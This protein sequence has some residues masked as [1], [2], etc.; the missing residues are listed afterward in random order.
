MKITTL[1]EEA[2]TSMPQICAEYAEYLAIHALDRIE[3]DSLV[4]EFT[5]ERYPIYYSDL[6]RWFIDCPNSWEFCEQAV[7]NGAVDFSSFSMPDLLTAGWIEWAKSKIERF[8][9]QIA[10]LAALTLLEKSHDYLPENFGELMSDAEDADTVGDFRE[11]F[12]T[13]E[14]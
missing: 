2:K 3:L 11:I 4:G 5:E 12:T 13:E 1:I 9:K 14:E 8:D 7:E 6:N 10:E